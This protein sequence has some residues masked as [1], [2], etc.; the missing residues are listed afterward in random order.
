MSGLPVRKEDG[1]TYQDYLQFPDEQRCEII[2]GEA[3]DMTPAPTT[4]HQRVTGEIL[5]VIRSHLGGKMLPCRVFV[6]PVDVILS[7]AD[8]VQPDVVIVCDR[9]KIQRRGIFGAPEVVFEVLSPSTE[10]KDRRKKMELYERSGVR[11]YF[12]VNPEAEF[13][14]K[15]DLS[16]AGYG[17]SVLYEG[18][19]TFMIETIG[20]ELAVQDIFPREGEEGGGS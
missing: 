7:E 18:K 3:F 13:I 5:Y 10:P 6:S 16:P 15:Y 11:E 14:E 1:Y 12:L 19:E 8:V 9:S 2:D 20:L 4:D 17:K